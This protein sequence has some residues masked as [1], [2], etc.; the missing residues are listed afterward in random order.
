MQFQANFTIGVVTMTDHH[1]A[2]Y[3]P[4]S[5]ERTKN[6]VK[7]LLPGGRDK[8]DVVSVDDH[9]RRAEADAWLVAQPD[10]PVRFMYQDGP[11]GRDVE[12]GYADEV[13]EAIAEAETEH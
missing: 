3:V 1:P 6:V 4:L 11:G 8:I 12:F 10:G 13:R 7:N 5:T 2:S 9:A